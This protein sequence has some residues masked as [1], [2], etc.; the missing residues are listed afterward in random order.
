MHG[1]RTRWRIHRRQLVSAIALL[2]AGVPIVASAEGGLKG[3][4]IGTDAPVDHLEAIGI[5]GD[6]AYESPNF[7]YAITW[8]RNWIVPLD[9]PGSSDPVEELD[10][11]RLRWDG[12]AASAEPVAQIEFNGFTALDDDIDSFLETITDPK[13]LARLHGGGY[14]VD[15][16]VVESQGDVLETAWRLVS[17]DDPDDVSH[18]V[19]VFRR[20]EP[21]L[22]LMATISIV[23]ADLVSEVVA[24]LLAGIQFNDEA[25][26]QKLTLATIEDGF[27]ALD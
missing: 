16:A 10:V 26:V 18:L 9:M 24:D 11:L 1:E 23:E 2:V 27:A 3:G 5:V 20:L 25:L 19:S 6:N 22:L 15:M 12:D 13:V 4:E 21:G 7:G 8:N 14:T 17:I